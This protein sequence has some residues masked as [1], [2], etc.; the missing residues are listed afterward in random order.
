[1]IG[2]HDDLLEVLDA[3]EIESLDRYSI[4]GEPREVGERHFT[5]TSLPPEPTLLVVSLGRDLYERLYFRPSAQRAL[6]R[7]DV[8]AQRDF[9]AALSAA[10]SGLGAWQ[11]G[12]TVRRIDHG[13]MVVVAKDD[14]EFWSPLSDVMLADGTIEPMKGCRVRV[15]KELRQLKSGFQVAI[16]D[17]V[18]SA[19]AGSENGDSLDRYYWHLRVNTAVRFMGAT[20]SRLN[21]IRVP[22][23]VKLLNDP[24]AYHRA[25]AGVL[26]ASRNHR[27]LIGTI[28]AE[29]H[30]IIA[31]GLRSPVPLFTRRLADGLGFAEDPNSAL[32]F[33]E[34]RC[35]LIAAALW[36]SFIH[37]E[38]Q[39]DAHSAT[40]AAAYLK[41]GLDPRR[42]YRGPGS[43]DDETLDTLES[44]ISLAKRTAVNWK[45]NEIAPMPAASP[46]AA[47]PLEAAKR[48]G[49]ILCR[50]TYWDVDGLHCN[51]MGR[52]TAEALEPGGPIT[53][54][55]SA[56][57]PDLYG[58]SAGIALF[59]TQLH[60]L[61]G[62]PESRRVAIGAI[63]RSIRQLD[64]LPTTEPVSPLSLYCGHLGVAYVAQTV[65]ELTEH[66]GLAAQARSIL[67]RVADSIACA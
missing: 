26:Y 24:N 49:S 35:Q 47:S 5:E 22:F 8:V 56:V 66:S 20:T 39:R 17:S 9:A 48:I 4:L 67:D 55:T 38:V 42:P 43:L 40:V 60:A 12:W 21:A 54:M 36:E 18:G 50:S 1:M 57:G 29:I 44:Q 2:L 58:G 10:N 15:A 34:H 63:A 23:H 11:P 3:V 13:G 6:P 46:A 32:S 53:Q 51:W 45:I 65:A 16:G 64:R 25:D 31:S 28:I 14:V 19:G 61:S 52:S 27:G 30:S 33:G 37:G 62:N 41:A 59:L 7:T